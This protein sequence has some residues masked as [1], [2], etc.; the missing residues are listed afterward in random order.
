MLGQGMGVTSTSPWE[1]SLNQVSSGAGH[2]QRRSVV[3]AF[4]GYRLDRRLLDHLAQNGLTV[5][6]L[7]PLVNHDHKHA[8]VTG[9]A[10]HLRHA[11]CQARG[12]GQSLS[13][14]KGAGKAAPMVQDRHS[15]LIHQAHHLR[16]RERVEDV[17]DVGRVLAK[18]GGKHLLHKVLGGAPLLLPQQ[19]P[20]NP[21]PCTFI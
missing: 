2:E 4:D 18:H 19:D 1:C 14:N 9:A 10:I 17:H 12:N 5:L 8:P 7:L 11:V 13:D 21:K 16:W 6:G 20:T 3:A 15:V